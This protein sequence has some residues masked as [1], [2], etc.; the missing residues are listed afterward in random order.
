M[1]ATPSIRS[2]TDAALVTLFVALEL[3]R[4]T[5]LV[6][7]SG[8]AGRRV[9]LLGTSYWLHYKH[10]VQAQ[11]R[12]SPPDFPTPAIASVIGLRIWLGR[13]GTA[14]RHSEWTR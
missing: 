13:S 14:I 10:V 2:P 11:R 5:A 12:P 4:S 6:H 9:G 1:D 8:E 3:S 7:G